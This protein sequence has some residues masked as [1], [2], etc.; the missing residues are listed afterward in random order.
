[1]KPKGKFKKKFTETQKTALAKAALNAKLATET[2]VSLFGV[3]VSRSG[4]FASRGLVRLEAYWNLFPGYAFLMWL[5]G[6]KSKTGFN[7]QFW[8]LEYFPRTSGARYARILFYFNPTTSIKTHTSPGFKCGTIGKRPSHPLEL[9]VQAVFIF[10]IQIKT[11]TP[12][13]SSS[14]RFV[15]DENIFRWSKG[16]LQQFFE[17]LL[18]RWI[19]KC[20]PS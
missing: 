19:W 9:S 7:S 2:I 20:V 14:W 15:I 3:R 4:G 11:H 5:K 12:M 8:S 16:I 13:F 18:W 1:M 10:V 6:Q 17:C